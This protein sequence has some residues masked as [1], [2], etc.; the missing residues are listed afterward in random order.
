M[1]STRSSFLYG[2]LISDQVNQYLNFYDGASQKTATIPIGSYSATSFMNMVQSKMRAVSTLLYTV[3]FNRATRIVTISADGPFTL[4]PETGY[5]ASASCF[6]L[7]GFTTDRAS[8][9]SHVGNTTSGYIYRPQFYL[10]SYIG[11]EDYQMAVSESIN[12][13]ASGDIE[14]VRFGTNKFVEFQIQ[15]AT[16]IAMATNAPI[17]NNASGVNEL[18]AFMQDITQKRL[19]EFLPDRNS[20]SGYQVLLLETT[21]S[22]GT[23]TGYKLKEQY[24]KGLAGM[25]S[26]GTLKFR[27]RG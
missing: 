21:E 15:Y 20:P 11:S 3:S 12:Q 1:I 7:L 23:G 27:V 26:S 25:F 24:D 10:Q 6:S 19:I 14:V 18:R 5:N 16:D 9:T 2:Y 13:S 22:S 4:L 8:A 17:E